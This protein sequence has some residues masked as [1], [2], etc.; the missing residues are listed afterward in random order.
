MVYWPI[1]AFDPFKLHHYVAP[2]THAPIVFNQSFAGLYF[3]TSLALWLAFM[4]FHGYVSPPLARVEH[5]CALTASVSVPGQ[6]KV[7]SETAYKRADAIGNASFTLVSLKF[8]LFLL[9]C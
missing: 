5:R 6:V 9:S 1:A 8:G 7:W 4:S 3:F 2:A